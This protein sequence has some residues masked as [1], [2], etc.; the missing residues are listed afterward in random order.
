MGQE[1]CM[2]MCVYKQQHICLLIAML[3]RNQL[4]YNSEVARKCLVSE[5]MEIGT[6]M[7]KQICLGEQSCHP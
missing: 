6:E 4:I 3:K 1:K 7:E 2:C 5:K